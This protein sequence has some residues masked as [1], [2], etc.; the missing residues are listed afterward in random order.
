M[1][2]GSS[3]AVDPTDISDWDGGVVT[4]SQERM[5][6]T[7]GQPEKQRKEVERGGGSMPLPVFY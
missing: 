1:L 3:E 5:R 6:E 2:L 7:G 4:G